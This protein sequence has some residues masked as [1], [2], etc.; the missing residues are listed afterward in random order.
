MREL[1]ANVY[2]QV[3]DFTNDD[4]TTSKGD[5]DERLQVSWKI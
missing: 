4:V 1:E 3:E 5:D 2:L